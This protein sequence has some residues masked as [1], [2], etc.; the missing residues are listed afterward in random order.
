MLACAGMTT[1]VGG[2]ASI[3]LVITHLAQ[4]FR[5]RSPLRR[6]CGAESGK[7]FEVQRLL[8][9]NGLPHVRHGPSLAGDDALL[10]RFH[11]VQKLAQM[12]LRVSE[13]DGEHGRFLSDRKLVMT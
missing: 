10:T 8:W 7:R 3:A 4:L 9:R 2:Y 5:A 11:L 6:Q 13:T 12:G 1:K